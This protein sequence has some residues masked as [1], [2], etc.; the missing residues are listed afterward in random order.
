MSSE[1]GTLKYAERH[2]DLEVP[3][4]IAMKGTLSLRQRAT[5]SES[6]HLFIH[7]R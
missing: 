6:Q 5:E 4:A 1:G 2:C 3:A 7:L